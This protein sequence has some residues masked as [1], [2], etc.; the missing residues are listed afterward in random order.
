MP[1]KHHWL[2]TLRGNQLHWCLDVTLQQQQGFFETIKD[3]EWNWDRWIHNYVTNLYLFE[4]N[5]PENVRLRLQLNSAITESALRR[6]WR[7]NP[8]VLV[9]FLRHK[10][11]RLFVSVKDY[12]PQNA[13]GYHK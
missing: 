13:G 1:T 5:E 7:K 8:T 4:F 6:A 10:G 11:T 9:K 12:P 3:P 2:I